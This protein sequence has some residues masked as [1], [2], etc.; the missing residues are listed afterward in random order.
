MHPPTATHSHG[1]EHTAHLRQLSGDPT[2]TATIRRNFVRAVRRRFRRLRGRTRSVVGYEE[3]RLHL[4]Q[5]ARLEEDDPE[6]IE[7][8]PTDGGKRAAFMTWLKAYLAEEVLQ[9]VPARE[10]ASGTHWSAAYVRAAFRTGYETARARLRNEGV[11]VGGPEENPLQIGVAQSTLRRLYQRTYGNLASITDDAVA[12][13]RDELTR[14]LAEGVNPREM[15]RRLSKEVRTVQR[16]QAEVLART[17]VV[18]AHTQA[19]LARYDEANVDQVAVSGEFTTAQD[20]RVCPICESIAGE[21]FELDAMRG[22]SETFRFEPAA[23][24]P[25]HLA[26]EYRIAPPVHPQ[27]R[28]TLLPVIG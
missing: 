23:D 17:E 5:G 16:S 26:G 22:D 10:V 24:E 28:C 21:V 11:A 13:V 1:D 6:N 18:N 20:N 8:F 7:R 2:G 27:C 15:A 25:D 3:D 19:A 14:G 9:R 4:R 12:A